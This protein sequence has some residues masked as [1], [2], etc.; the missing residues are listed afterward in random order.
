MFLRLAY[1]EPFSNYLPLHSSS[2]SLD[3]AVN[4]KPEGPYMSDKQRDHEVRKVKETTQKLKE[5][6]EKLKR[7]LRK[8]RRILKD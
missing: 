7:K 2:T 3:G 8:I 6:S 5:D 4:I 1:T